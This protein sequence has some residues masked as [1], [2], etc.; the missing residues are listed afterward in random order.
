MT[1]YREVQPLEIGE[2]VIIPM[3]SDFGPGQSGKYLGPSSDLTRVQVGTF[4]WGIP[5]EVAKDLRRP[6]DVGDRVKILA[7]VYG[8][9]TGTIVERGAWGDLLVRGYDGSVARYGENGL[10]R[11]NPEDE[12]LKEGDRVVFGGAQGTVETVDHRRQIVWVFFDYGK[13]NWYRISDVKKVDVSVFDTTKV[14]LAQLKESFPVPP[15]GLYWELAAQSDDEEPGVVAFEVSLMIERED[16]EDLCVK[17]T[18]VPWPEGDLE[19]DVFEG[20]LVAAIHLADW[21]P[22]DMEKFK[23]AQEIDR[24]FGRKGSA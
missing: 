22:K 9:T 11:L 2:T 15:K 5:P 20:I 19:S 23:R 1:N 3:S 12:P 16:A 24:A 4:V 17:Y 8:E 6:L 21:F 18:N 13:G 10:A 7:S 14:D